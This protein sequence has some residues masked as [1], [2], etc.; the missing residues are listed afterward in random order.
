[1]GKNGPKP[2][3]VGCGEKVPASAAERDGVRRAVRAHVARKGLVPPL[4]LDELRSEADELLRAGGATE[5][6]HDFVTV[7]LNNEVWRDAFEATPFERRIL[8]LP[9]CLRS[10]TDCPA[11]VDEFGLLCEG[12]GAC[13][14]AGLQ[15]IAE[16]LGY[17]VLVAEGTTVVTELLK[18]GKIDAVVGVSC[19]ETLERSFPYAVMHAVPGLAVPL[20]KNGCSDTCVDLGWVR[21]ALTSAA[22]GGFSARLDLDGLRDEVRSWFAPAALAEL[23]GP[24][25][26][27]TEQIARDWVAK[28]G[29]RWRPF[30]AAAVFRAATGGEQPF[31]EA[32]RRL[33]VAIECFHKASLVHDDIEDDDDLRYDDATLHRVHGVPIALNAGDLLLGE[34]YRQI[35]GCGLPPEQTVR[36]VSVAADAHRELCLGQGEELL[37]VRGGTALSA[38]TVLKIF[39]LKTSPAFRVSLEFGA[40][41]AGC[42]AGVLAAL[43][44]FSDALG[45]AYQIKDDLDEYRGGETSP[46]PG[47]I[48]PSLVRALACERPASAAAAEAERLLDRYR[49][50]ALRTLKPVRDAELKTLLHRLVGRILG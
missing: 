35:A 38:E 15:R 19:L 17:V 10:S 41:L 2:Q 33:C 27:A 45:V 7:L 9:Q 29:K 46:H 12:C 28:A 6:S 13:E 50:A 4:C 22:S 16:E 37:G 49:E 23:L 32:V 14:I 24:A 11:E 43:G 42:D 31:Q 47:R 8:M 44:E 39:S 36:L 26:T 3:A 18:Q 30:L 34:G 40:I 20:L 21:E 25:E 1:M 48:S 5:N